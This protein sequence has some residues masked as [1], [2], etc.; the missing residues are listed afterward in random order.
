[1]QK[2]LP[3]LNEADEYD[4]YATESGSVL[5]Y[6]WAH[7]FKCASKRTCETW[8]VGGPLRTDDRSEKMSRRY[9]RGSTTPIG[10]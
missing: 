6:C 1:M 3:P 9:G 7:H 8:V 2:C 4:H 10:T 5:G